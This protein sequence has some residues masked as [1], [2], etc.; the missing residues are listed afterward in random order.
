[1]SVLHNESAK[2]NIIN[3]NHDVLNKSTTII[4]QMFN[5]IKYLISLTYYY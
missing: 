2:G 3:V 4:L 5:S 1:M